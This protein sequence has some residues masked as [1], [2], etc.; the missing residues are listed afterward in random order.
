[1]KI[2]VTG[3]AG[4][5]G[6]HLA[7]RLVERGDDVTIVDNLLTGNRK[8]VSPKA[9]F[10]EMDIRDPKIPDLFEKERFDLLVHFAAQMDIRT[11]TRDP[12][13]DADINILGGLNL[14]ESARKTGVGRVVFSSTG[15]A[16]YGDASVMPTPE[17]YPAWPMSPYG[18]AK[19]TVEHYLYYYKTVFHLPSLILRFANVYG[20]RQNPHGEANV[21]AIFIQKLLTGEQPIINGD[22]TQTRDFLYVGDLVDAAMRGIE[23]G[24]EGTFNLGTTIETN[25]NQIFDRL[26]A[27]SGIAKDSVHGPAKKGEQMRSQLAIAKAE[28]ALGWK[29]KT[30]LDEG[31]KQTLEFFRGQCST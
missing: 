20:P 12:K 19:L 31:L 16:L 4:F 3:G 27:I 21:V 18:V 30:T 25:V 13:F 14:L 1:M 2:C 17:D 11:S 15:G 7:D 6:S 5:I 29:P 26:V 8:W 23:Q 24:S 28:Q 22:G 9:R 10:L